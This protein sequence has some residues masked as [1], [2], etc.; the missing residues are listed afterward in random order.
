LKLSEEGTKDLR[1]DPELAHLAA[2]K[3]KVLSH[4]LRLRIVA[5]LSETATHDNA[6]AEELSVPQSVVSQHLRILRM[7]GLVDV[8]R[9]DGFSIYHLLEPKIINLLSCV[10]S[11]DWS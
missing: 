11:C 3:I 2:N 7:E 1:A 10:E 4:P 6:L 9:R 5:I 8:E